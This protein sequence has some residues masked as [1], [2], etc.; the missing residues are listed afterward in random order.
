MA[1]ETPRRRHEGMISGPILPQMVAWQAADELVVFE[2]GCKESFV[3]KPIRLGRR[4][5]PQTG[6]GEPAYLMHLRVLVTVCGEGSLPCRLVNIVW[7][8]F[9]NAGNPCAWEEADELD[10]LGE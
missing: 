6:A 1:Q 4:R 8:I 5:H 9:D 10:E 7:I 3:G 2:R